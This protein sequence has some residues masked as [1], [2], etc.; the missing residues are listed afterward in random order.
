MSTLILMEPENASYFFKRGEMYQAFAQHT[1]AI[2]D[3]NKV[4]SLEPNNSMAYYKRASCNEQLMKFEEAIKDY[5]MLAKLSK[6]DIKAQELLAEAQKRL[7]E[8]NA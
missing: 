5:E 8:L 6:Y 7:F 2:S 4:I 1:A 3:F